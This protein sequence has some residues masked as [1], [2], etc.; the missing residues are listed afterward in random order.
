MN[1]QLDYP[2]LLPFAWLYGLG[3][4]VRNIL[5][6]S[7]ILRSVEFHDIPVISVGNLSVG[8][9]GKTPHTEY[10][11]RLLHDSHRVAVLS[12]GYRRHT[13]GF[14]LASHAS[15]PAVVG[16]EPFQMY[17]KFP[18]IT[19]A[20]DEDR[21]HG[22]ELLSA[23]F[24]A[25]KLSERP[26]CVVLDDAYQH[27][28]VKPGLNI[29]LVDYNHPIYH[30]YLLPAG[31]LRELRKRADRADIIIMTKCPP[32]VS[33]TEQNA[34]EQQLH[35]HHWQQV[36]YSTYTYSQ[37]P[38]N[39]SVLLVTGIANPQPLEDRLTEL[40][41]DVK[42]IRFADHH[43]YTSTD[44]QHIRSISDGRIIVTTE[45]DDVKLREFAVSGLTYHIASINVKILNNQEQIFNKIITD[46][47]NQGTW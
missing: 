26:A 23:M 16:D 12:R 37:L 44:I 33:P 29:L 32:Y 43:D 21:C 7:G 27:R 41:N 6:D 20:V 13:K 42:S 2:F 17:R 22:I 24:Q 25:D 45:K 4:E 1:H 46:Y 47:A 30:D 40:G 5:Y 35:P 34:I 36:F 10:L 19:V 31:R 39:S 9:T 3:T 15:F 28:R 18:D 8:G 38:E 11:V 14:Q